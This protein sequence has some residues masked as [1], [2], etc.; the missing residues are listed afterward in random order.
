MTMNAKVTT[1]T[2]SKYQI[3]TDS[4]SYAE[5]EE[6]GSL[7]EALEDFGAPKSVRDADSFAAWLE[8]VGGYGWIEI[9]GERICEVS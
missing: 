9:D 8:R 2:K 1:G 7:A 4:G 3:L 6:F 5:P